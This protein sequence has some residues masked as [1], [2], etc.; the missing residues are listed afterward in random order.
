MR[1]LTTP[2]YLLAV[3]ATFAMPRAGTWANP[4]PPAHAEP[5]E[6]KAEVKKVVKPAVK[7]VMLEGKPAATPAA[8]PGTKPAATPPKLPE[9]KVVKE[10]KETKGATSSTEASEGDAEPAEITTA[11]QAMAALKR[12]NQRW[13]AGT[14]THPSTG[15]LRIKQTGE[16]GQKPFV[17]IITCADSRIPVERVFDRGVGEMFVVRVA[18]NITSTALTGTVE[19]GVGHLHTPLLVVMGH[20]KCGAVK[21]TVEAL[22]AKGTLGPNIAALAASITPAVHRARKQSPSAVG[23]ELVELAVRENIWQTIFDLYKASAE[24]VAQVQEGK[25]KVIGAVLDISTGQVEWLGEHPWQETLLSA[26]AKPAEVL[27]ATPAPASTATPT[28]AATPAPEPATATAEKPTHDE[29][30]HR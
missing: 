26:L 20:S 22:E 13:V 17:S 9:P 6:A 3:F 15:M 28:A 14:P 18:G 4:E 30:A 5:A 8:K 24:L 16:G 11:E 12:G 25:L 23:A 2:A 1:T 19:Y 21:A 29:P 7:P 10:A 27:A